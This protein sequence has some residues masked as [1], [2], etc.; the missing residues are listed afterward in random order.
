MIE[1]IGD[2][3]ECIAIPRRIDPDPFPPREESERSDERGLLITGNYALAIRRGGP[4]GGK[5]GGSRDR[6]QGGKTAEMEGRKERCVHRR[7]R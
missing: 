4:E 2:R 6:K 5:A 7:I 3:A 1:R